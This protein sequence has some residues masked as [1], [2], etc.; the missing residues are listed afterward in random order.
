M[1]IRE[2]WNLKPP[3]IFLRPKNIQNFEQKR[4]NFLIACLLI[5]TLAFGGNNEESKLETEEDLKTAWQA[6]SH[7]NVLVK[8]TTDAM[9]W[10]FDDF[11]R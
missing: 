5:A 6:Q 7:N 8:K 3:N 11:N 10:K 2:V 9:G 1:I 4:W